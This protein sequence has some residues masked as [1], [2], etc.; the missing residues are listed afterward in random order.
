MQ[1]IH[2]C[3]LWTSGSLFIHSSL[4]LQLW[5]LLFIP[6]ESIITL[7]AKCN[8]HVMRHSVTWLP[9]S[10]LLHLPVQSPPIVCSHALYA[11]ILDNDAFPSEMIILDNSLS[12]HD[13]VTFQR[14]YASVQ[15]NCSLRPPKNR[16]IFPLYLYQ[17]PT[18]F[19]TYPGE[20]STPN[21]LL[22]I[23]SASFFCCLSV[24]PPDKIQKTQ[25]LP[26]YAD[27]CQH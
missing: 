24:Y 21:M 13:F 16:L 20:S 14:S 11:R 25:C 15:I 19:I 27:C 17:S 18:G 22:T 5:V 23:S 4:C 26:N 3:H 10:L 9:S 7:H 2:P 8:R 6:K 12:H 1:Q